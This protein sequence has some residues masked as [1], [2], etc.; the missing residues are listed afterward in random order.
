MFLKHS[1]MLFEVLSINKVS[2]LGAKK[3]L[4]GSYSK[5]CEKFTIIQNQTEPTKFITSY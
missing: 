4:L 3:A 1:I 2:L 5:H